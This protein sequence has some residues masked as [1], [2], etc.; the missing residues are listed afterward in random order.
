MIKCFLLILSTIHFSVFA[1]QNQL[2]V[3][4][5]NSEL[6][7][8]YTFVE[9]SLNQS[10][11][12]I[13]NSSGKILFDDVGITVNVLSPFEEN[14]R[15]EGGI[16]EIHDLFTDQKQSIDVDQANNFFLDILIDGIDENNQ[17]Y[18][19]NIIDNASIE[20]ISVD[21]N[22]FINFLFFENRLDLI[23]Y[24]DSIGVEHG[25]ELTPL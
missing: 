20:I 13:E 10:A 7:K 24:K 3:S 8:N 23:R 18:N 17:T 1:D 9:R 22:A 14:Y 21:Q 5:L 12:K 25:I 11:M 6:K 15:I 16:I 2:S 4:L 19:I